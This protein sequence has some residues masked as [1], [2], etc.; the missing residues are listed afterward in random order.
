[1]APSRVSTAS[2]APISPKTNNDGASHSDFQKRLSLVTASATALPDSPRAITPRRSSQYHAASS[3]G[4]A[5]P[6]GSLRRSSSSLSTNRR[7]STPTLTKKNSMSSLQSVVGVTSPQ[8]PKRRSSTHFNSS[9]SP[10]AGRIDEAP[11]PIPPPTAASVASAYFKG[12][13]DMHSRTE[14]AAESKFQKTIVILHDSCYGHRY[15]RPRTSKAS[16]NSIVERPE[17]LLASVLGVATAY[18]RLGG[19]HAGGECPPHPTKKPQSIPNIPFRIYKTTRSVPLTSPVVANVHGTKWMEELKLMCDNAEAKLALN[20]KELVRPEIKGTGADKEERPKFHEGDLY[21]CSDTLEALEGAI[22]AVCD[23]VDRVFSAPGPS[24]AFVC[25]RPPGHHCSSNYPSGF[26]WLNNV[27]VGIS[28]ASVAHGLTH[29][30]IIDFDLHHGDGSQ[31]ITWAHNARIAPKNAASS[32]RPFIG[33]FSLHDI[34]SYPCEMGD[35]EKIRNASL[36]L[37]NAHGQTIWNVHLQPWKDEVEFWKL[38]ET[39]YTVLIDKARGFLR[40]HTQ[41]INASTNQL[42]PKAAIFL[43]SGFDASQWESPGM[44]RHKV[45]VPTEFYARFTRDVVNLAEEDGTGV[46]GRIIS[47]LEGGY[48][49][50]A[51]CSG[52][53]S[54]LSGLVGGDPA[55][56]EF[57]ENGLRA[58]MSKRLGTVDE[59]EGNEVSPESPAEVPYNPDWWAL[60][61]LMELEA[62]VNPPPPPP[63]PKKPRNPTPPTYATPTQSFTAKIVS[64]PKIRRSVSG[65]SGSASPRVILSRPSSPVYPDVD[66]ATAAHELSKLLIP[67]ERQTRSW[68]PEDLSAEAQR[69]KR[70]RHSVVGLPN[71]QVGDGTRRSLRERKV[72]APTPAVEEEE[73]EILPVKRESRRNTLAGAELIAEKA[74]ARG[75]TSI[76]NGPIPIRQSGRRMSVASSTGSAGSDMSRQ[77]SSDLSRLQLANGPPSRTSSRSGTTTGARAGSSMSV[78][79]EGSNGALK[80]ARVPGQSGVGPPK[81]RG[82]RKQPLTSHHTTTSNGDSAAYQTTSSGGAVVPGASSLVSSKSDSDKDLDGLTS[83]VKKITLHVPTREEHDMRERKRIED[84]KGAQK[85]PRKTAAPKAPKVAAV[86]NPRPKELIGDTISLGLSGTGANSKD[87]SGEPATQVAV[88]TN[89][90]SPPLQHAPVQTAVPTSDDSGSVHIQFIPY[91]GDAPQI[92]SQTPKAP[93]VWMP[94]NENTPPPTRKNDLPVFTAKSPI[95]FAKA[96][97]QIPQGSELRSKDMARDSGGTAM[98]RDGGDGSRV[99][100]VNDRRA[101]A[102]GNMDGACEKEGADG[103][104]VD[105]WDVPDT[106]KR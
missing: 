63:I 50:R 40:A 64:S 71:V 78:R 29:A 36:C 55:P 20:G 21:L 61:Q 74:S 82:A 24:R 27:N 106:P 26:C 94:V 2:S 25:I 57:Q 95:V 66:W 9:P 56:E 45:N 104:E 13:L 49:D 33:Y 48:S 102:N 38:Y 80:K 87:M 51:L 84:K 14:K 12:E 77:V 3:P 7:A 4:T 97:G 76:G 73:D 31:A 92:H 81:A 101:R 88:E 52:V 32:K 72:R 70:E 10:L 58:E 86:R 103:N 16:L 15:S 79:G 67:T 8:S 89:E 28:H 105:I 44:Q 34:N 1:M 68:R 11:E 46:N 99:I 23:G 54:H 65:T 90:A 53:L 30:A 85:P 43:S 5:A 19:R 22:G 91:A 60:P 83:A 42:Q 93:L 75:A 96:N 17:R 47:V 6:P 37:E 35:E 98:V 100:D 59:C 39:R 41:R 69:A 62:L 18:V